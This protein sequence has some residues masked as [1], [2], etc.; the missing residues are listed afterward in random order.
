MEYRDYNSNLRDDLDRLT[1]ENAYLDSI[2]N[3]I[4]NKKNCNNEEI[5]I[6]EKL[7]AIR[8]NAVQ[9]TLLE[10]IPTILNSIREKRFGGAPEISFR[11]RKGVADTFTKCV[12]ECVRNNPTGIMT[13]DIVEFIRPKFPN[14]KNMKGATSFVLSQLRKKKVIDGIEVQDRKNTYLWKPIDVTVKNEDD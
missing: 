4:Q 3:G 12:Y 9:N 14:K 5:E 1:K 13:S 8:D 7:L 6:I 11:T 10:H 2:M